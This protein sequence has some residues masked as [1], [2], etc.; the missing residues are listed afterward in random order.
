MIVYRFAHPK[1]ANDLSGNGARLKGGRWNN[2]G[3]P[4]IY[5]SA[6]ISLALL[7]VLAN[8]L[9][10]DELQLM[11]LMEIEL[12]IS[13]KQQQ[14]SLQNLKNNWYLDFDYTQWLGSEILR[15]KE[16]LHFQCPSALVQSEYNYLINPLHP[17]FKK[18]T[19]KRT[20]PFHFD[21][22]LFKTVSSN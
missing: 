15:S 11:R 12:P 16:T 1:F 18:V 10:L 6:T 13:E 21:E 22:R 3:T 7:E 2:V 19:I 17:A 5:T 14:I 4:V 9:T 8:A 20:A